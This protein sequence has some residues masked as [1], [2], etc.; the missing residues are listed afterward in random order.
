MHTH[1]EHKP[2]VDG[3]GT[4]A[5][6]LIHPLSGERIVF[7]KRSRDTAERGLRH[8]TPSL[9]STIIHADGVNA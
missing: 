8:W 6:P 2:T 7:R 9:A 3:I 4:E 1:P 5:S